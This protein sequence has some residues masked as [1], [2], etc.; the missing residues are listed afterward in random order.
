MNK[1]QAIDLLM[2]LSS[3]ES[4]SFAAKCDFPDYLHERLHEQID[5]LRKQALGEHEHE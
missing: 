1:P 3:L 4:W 2:L 5:L